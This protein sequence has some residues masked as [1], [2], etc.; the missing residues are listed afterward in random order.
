VQSK[1]FL[2]SVQL[3]KALPQCAIR[4]GR[5]WD[6]KE[7]DYRAIPTCGG[8]YKVNTGYC[9]KCGGFVNP[10]LKNEVKGFTAEGFNLLKCELN[11]KRSSHAGFKQK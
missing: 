3:M 11:Q 4:L 5:V 8:N 6:T 7:G 2:K 1:T 10:M 9:I